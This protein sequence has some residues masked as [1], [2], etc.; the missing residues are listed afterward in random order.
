MDKKVIGYSKDNFRDEIDEFKGNKSKEKK[1]ETDKLVQDNIKRQSLNDELSENTVLNDIKN[2]NLKSAVN[3]L[4]SRNKKQ[5][6]PDILKQNPKKLAK[7]VGKTLDNIGKKKTVKL[8][9]ATEKSQKLLHNKF[10]EQSPKDGQSVEPNVKAH[11]QRKR[12]RRLEIQKPKPKFDKP[13]KPEF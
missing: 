7:E 11:T 5:I 2:G 12:S 6:N 8:T 10:N 3:E 13:I 1:P 9:K 4:N